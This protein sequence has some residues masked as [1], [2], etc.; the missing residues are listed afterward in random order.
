MTRRYEED[1][2]TAVTAARVAERLPHRGAAGKLRRLLET[3]GAIGSF[4]DPMG[5]YARLP[6]LLQ[7]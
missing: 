4:D 6:V 3:V 1:E 5:L 7:F 2:R